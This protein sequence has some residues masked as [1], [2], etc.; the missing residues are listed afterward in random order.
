MLRL[1]AEE[2]SDGAIAP[3]SCEAVKKALAHQIKEAL[4]R[5][6]LPPQKRKTKPIPR[7]T[8]KKLVQS[9]QQKWKINCCRET[10]RKA[11]K[12]M[13]F[14][15]KK[16]KKLLNK[17]SKVKRDE[18]LQKITELLNDA[19]HQRHLLLYIDEAH[20]HLDTDE[21]YGWSIEGERF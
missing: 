10:V 19:L 5:A 16:A 9:I 17:A 21:G 14:S 1:Y 7:W 8:L 11:L 3:S 15:W 4:F 2:T 18:F 20:I 13:S 12:K 6:A